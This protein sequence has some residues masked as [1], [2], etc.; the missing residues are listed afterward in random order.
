MALRLSDLRFQIYN[1]GLLGV[2]IGGSLGFATLYPT[3][4]F[5]LNFYAD[6]NGVA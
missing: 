6:K 5:V 2:G 1:A 4:A 3:Y